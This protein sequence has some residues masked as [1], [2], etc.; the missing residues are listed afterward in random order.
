MKTTSR[1]RFYVLLLWA[2][3]TTALAQRDTLTMRIPTAIAAGEYAEAKM[4]IEEAIKA[5]VITAAVAAGTSSGI[6]KSSHGVVLRNAQ[7]NAKA[8]NIHKDSPR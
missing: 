6:R 3:C 2:L 5:G 7:A 8:G 4:L 1:R